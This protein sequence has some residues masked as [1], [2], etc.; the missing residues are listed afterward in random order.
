MKKLMRKLVLS[1]FAL[2][3]AVITL[4]TTTFAWYTNNVDVTANGV[5]GESSTSGSALLMISQDTEKW[6][7]T[8][9]VTT[10]NGNNGFD[11]MIPLQITVGH[12]A[13]DHLFKAWDPATGNV[14]SGDTTS[15]AYLTFD[16]WFKV[17]AETDHD[18]YLTKMNFTNT[19]GVTT[20]DTSIKL[21][22]KDV[23]TGG[24]TYFGKLEDNSDLQS[25]TYKVDILRTLMV[26]TTS[27]AYTGDSNYAG[28][29][30]ATTTYKYFNPEAL[31][32]ISE[33][34]LTGRTGFSAHDYYNH[35]MEKDMTATNIPTTELEATQG[36]VALTKSAAAGAAKGTLAEKQ[37]LATIPAA[38]VTDPTAN[39]VK[40]TFYIF[41]NGW[42][43][44]CFDA[45][46]GQSFTLDLAF[47]SEKVSTG[48]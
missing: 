16:L 25:A 2:G 43:L 29:T 27:K 10:S 37:K 28:S 4:S 35:V 3:L 20:S 30:T 47:Q 34:S 9:T 44:A 6:G 5:L 42:D 8:A 11:D 24:H 38:S 46:Q 19:T 23:L 14:V 41:I 17:Q 12:E 40:V 18:L 39:Y 36:A 13:T 22:T 1:S 7:T 45:V 15:S 21:P 48:A 32:E 33:D 26:A 31:C